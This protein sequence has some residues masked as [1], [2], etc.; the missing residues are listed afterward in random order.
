MPRRE[1]PPHLA[2][3]R[4]TEADLAG[5]DPVERQ[6]RTCFHCAQPYLTVA[7]AGRCERFHETGEIER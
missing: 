1:P 4:A 2:D 5:Y 6:F 7:D 3:R